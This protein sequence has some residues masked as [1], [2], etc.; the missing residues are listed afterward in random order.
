[1]PD[2]ALSIVLLF[3][4]FRLLEKGLLFL[5]IKIQDSC[6]LRLDNNQLAA[7]CFLHH[8]DQDISV[9]CQ[10]SNASTLNLFLYSSSSLKQH[11]RNLLKHSCVVS[12]DPESLN[13]WR[14]DY[15]YIVS[16]SSITIVV[17]L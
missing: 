13:P 6:L 5:W 2:F 4:D 8:L 7:S 14:L 10:P 9:P 16:V 12:P 11:Q 15:S 17:F 3:L 1:M